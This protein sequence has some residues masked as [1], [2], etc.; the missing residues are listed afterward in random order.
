MVEE[1]GV[2]AS[3]STALFPTTH[4]MT[5]VGVRD[6]NL[7]SPGPVPLHAIYQVRPRRAK[8]SDALISDLPASERLAELASNLHGVIA[9]DRQGRKRELGLLAQIA[10]VVPLRALTLPHDLGALS[11]VAAD[12]RPRLFG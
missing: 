9:P 5:K 11:R 3:I 6:P 7:F 8:G 4:E 1:L 10:A 2:D 12:L